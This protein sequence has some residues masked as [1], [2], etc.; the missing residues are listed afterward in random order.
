M[1]SYLF[2]LFFVVKKQRC[3][4]SLNVKW[5]H[6]IWASMIDG[7]IIFEDFQPIVIRVRYVTDRQT[8]CRSNTAICVASG[9]IRYSFRQTVVQRVYSFCDVKM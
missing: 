5:C 6:L 8:T 4:I 7:E 1:N 3:S 9:P 2:Y